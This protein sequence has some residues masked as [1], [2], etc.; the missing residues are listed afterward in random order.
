MPRA[1]DAIGRERPSLTC[2]TQPWRN[3]CSGVLVRTEPEPGPGMV[4]SW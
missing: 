1:D 2:M 3:P 4:D